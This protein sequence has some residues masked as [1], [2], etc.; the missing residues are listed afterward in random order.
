MATKRTNQKIPK[1]A[2]HTKK[3]R[4]EKKKGEGRRTAAIESTMHAGMTVVELSCFVR[5]IYVLYMYYI[6][7][8]LYTN[9]SASSFCFYSQICVFVAATRETR[10]TSREKRTGAHSAFRALPYFARFCCPLHVFFHMCTR[11]TDVC[12]RRQKRE[13]VLGRR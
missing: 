2:F 6:Y 13:D 8:Y 5:V 10:R 4:G 7:A 12:R 3:R 1:S 9:V 11:Y